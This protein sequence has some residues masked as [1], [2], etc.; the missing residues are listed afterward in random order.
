MARILLHGLAVFLH[1]FSATCAVR[2]SPAQRLALVDLE[3]HAS[4]ISRRLEGVADSPPCSHRGRRGK[5][6]A[7]DLLPLKDVVSS[8][9]H[10]DI[11]QLLLPPL[12]N[13]TTAVC[14]KGQWQHCDAEFLDDGIRLTRDEWRQRCATIT[15]ERKHHL[16]LETSKF[17]VLMR[18]GSLRRC[19]FR[20]ALLMWP[21]FVLA[22]S[23]RIRRYAEAYFALRSPL[24]F[25]TTRLECHGTSRKPSVNRDERKS[26]E[27]V[28]CER[29]MDGACLQRNSHT[30]WQNYSATLFLSEGSQGGHFVFTSHSTSE[31]RAVVPA[32]CGRAV[33]AAGDQPHSY[34]PLPNAKGCRLVLGFTHVAHQ[35]DRN[36]EALETAV[37]ETRQRLR[38]RRRPGS[39]SSPSTSTAFFV[40]PLRKHAP[41]SYQCRVMIVLGGVVPILACYVGFFSVKYHNHLYPHRKLDFSRFFDKFVN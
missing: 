16:G 7:D 18:N 19:R 3:D 11:P 35:R 15:C 8:G 21:T 34:L 12:F 26:G 17:G 29:Q 14:P 38:D 32:K 27:T 39:R 22:S 33:I 5:F 36:R 25:H 30:K 40:R 4:S 10:H 23:S 28:S 1:I 13:C 20:P 37:Y 41:M 6:C 2:R 24:N 31:I 9:C